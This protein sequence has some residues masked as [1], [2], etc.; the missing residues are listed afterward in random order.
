MTACDVIT[1]WKCSGCALYFDHQ[2]GLDKHYMNPRCKKVV[3]CSSCTINFKNLNRFLVHKES[4]DKV[5]EVIFPNFEAEEN[6]NFDI[7]R[8]EI[9]PVQLH[10]TQGTVGNEN[11]TNS[12]QTGKD[13][14]TPHPGYD[15][16]VNTILTD[17]VD[18]RPCGLDDKVSA[19]DI[20]QKYRLEVGFKIENPC[21]PDDEDLNTPYQCDSCN[22]TIKGQLI[23]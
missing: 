17:S 20:R 19:K 13:K 2:K 9:N 1:N 23:L 22:K 7:P 8:P 11:I 16:K 6:A 21:A 18:D 15:H 4:C 14:L 12:N 3:N 10:R 5:K